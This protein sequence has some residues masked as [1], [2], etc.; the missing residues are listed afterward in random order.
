MLVCLCVC[1]WRWMCGKG[2]FTYN[3]SYVLL[4][5]LILEKCFSSMILSLANHKVHD[6][7]FVLGVKGLKRE[8]PSFNTHTQMLF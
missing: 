2:Y 3:N 6:V 8:I 7:Y 5:I 4:N 1:I